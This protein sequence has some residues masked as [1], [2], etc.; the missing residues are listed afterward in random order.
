MPSFSPVGYSIIPGSGSLTTLDF[1]SAS[2]LH[3]PRLVHGSR[4]GSRSA[5]D[6]PR[7]TSPRS[8]SRVLRRRRGTPSSRPGRCRYSH[9]CLHP[10]PQS[11]RRTR[12]RRRPSRGRSSS[13]GPA[14]AH[15]SV[16]RT[17]VSV[18]TTSASLLLRLIPPS[19]P[20]AMLFEIPP[21][22]P[23]SD[24]PP[25]VAGFVTRSGTST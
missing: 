25:V 11:H 22:R 1:V 3:A 13:H 7:A 6:D 16:E 19:T 20:P 14:R 15:R 4:P 2:R 18:S 8:S 21:N 10:P 24:L 23:P 17:S 12:H 9:S 5:P